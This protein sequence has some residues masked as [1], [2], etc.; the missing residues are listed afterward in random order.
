MLQND[1]VFATEES[2]YESVYKLGLLSTC[3]ADSILRGWDNVKPNLQ[4]LQNIC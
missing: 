2:L 4:G 1:F 3:P